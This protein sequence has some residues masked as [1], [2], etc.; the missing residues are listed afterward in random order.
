MKFLIL[1]ILLIVGA[2]FSFGQS[3]ASDPFEPTLNTNI[4]PQYKSKYIYASND[5]KQIGFSLNGFIEYINRKGDVVAQCNIPNDFF[6]SQQ[7]PD[8]IFVCGINYQVQVEYRGLHKAMRIFDITIESKSKSRFTKTVYLNSLEPV[9]DEEIE[10]AQVGYVV[11]YTNVL[12]A[13]GTVY[14]GDEFICRFNA[15]LEPK[16][17]YEFTKIPDSCLNYTIEVSA[18]ATIPFEPQ[19]VSVRV[20][21]NFDQT[22]V[23]TEY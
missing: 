20:I 3:Y 19:G 22:V 8:L 14:R 11:K 10:V 16:N 12:H 18:G 4:S 15:L 5:L 7:G 9:S 13:S 17:I 6:F 23:T 1:K 21:D 2:F